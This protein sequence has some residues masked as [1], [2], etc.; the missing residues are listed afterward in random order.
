MKKPEPTT[1]ATQRAWDALADALAARGA[2]RSSMFGMPCVKT[3]A[4]KACVGLFGNAAVFKLAAPEHAEA[5]A[6]KGAVL[7]DPAGMGRPM[8]E[9]VVVAVA[10]QKQWARLGAA[11]LDVAKAAKRVASKAKALGRLP[12]RLRALFTPEHPTCGTRRS[13]SSPFSSRAGRRPTVEAGARTPTVARAGTTRSSRSRPPMT[14]A[15]GVRARRAWRP[16]RQDRPPVGSRSPACRW[17]L[18]RAR[19]TRRCPLLPRA[20]T[21][22]RRDVRYPSCP[23][24]GPPTRAPYAPAQ[25]PRAPAGA[26]ARPPQARRRRRARTSVRLRRSPPGYR[27]AAT[28]CPR[29]HSQPAPPPPR[30][31]RPPGAG[32]PGR[33]ND[34][35]DHPK[36]R[37]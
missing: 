19:P 33:Q 11:S 36:V 13:T 9:W 23:S 28:A 4:G 7:F 18:A 17:C 20:G 29:R 5:L 21:P 32:A 12:R 8:K 30:R 37:T 31:T 14:A 15:P 6:L 1:D 25:R 16:L 10:H 24:T 3:P 2:L 22:C 26:R 27:F 34:A 35:G